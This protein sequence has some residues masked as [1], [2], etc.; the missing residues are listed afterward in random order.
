[1]AAIDMG[2]VQKC[3]SY[4]SNVEIDKLVLQKAFGLLQGLIA[5]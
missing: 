2:R 5:V 1:M 4:I 3:H